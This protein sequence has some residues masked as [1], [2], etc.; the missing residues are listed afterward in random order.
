MFRAQLRQSVERL[1]AEAG[2][3]LGAR[4]YAAGGK[5]SETCDVIC[6]AYGKG[7]LPTAE[8]I[9]TIRDAVR[10]LQ[11]LLAAYGASGIPT[12]GDEPLPNSIIGMG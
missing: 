11:S 10:E 5:I 9:T 8:Q 7:L 4:G 3:N 6:L 1:R 12:A 2:L